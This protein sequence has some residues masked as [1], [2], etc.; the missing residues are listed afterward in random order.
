[1]NFKQKEGE[2]LG[3]SYKRFK[4]LLVACPTHNMDR[5][6]QMQMFVNGLLLKTKQLIDT[7]AGDSLNFSKATGMKKIIE[8]ITSNEHL[9]LYDRCSSKF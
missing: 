4:R 5:T 9:E 1:M 2:S 7:V 6:E 8:A 3:D